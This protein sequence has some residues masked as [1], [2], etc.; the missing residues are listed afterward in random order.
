MP[1]PIAP[2]PQKPIAGLDDILVFDW[3][4]VYAVFAEIGR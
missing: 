2:R 3:R 1:M 4:V